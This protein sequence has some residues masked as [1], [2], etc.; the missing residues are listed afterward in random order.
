MAKE[1]IGLSRFEHVPPPFEH[2]AEMYRFLDDSLLRM[3]AEHWRYG[4]YLVTPLDSPD[5]SP[6]LGIRW[7]RTIERDFGKLILTIADGRPS[8]SLVES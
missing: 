6:C 7:R 8:I 1:E 3:L 2:S 5:G 4:D